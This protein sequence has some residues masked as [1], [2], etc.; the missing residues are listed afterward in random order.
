[1][2]NT[3]ENP[4]EVQNKATKVDIKAGFATVFEFGGTAMK[5]LED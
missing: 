5:A 3:E 1:M 4:C 2:G